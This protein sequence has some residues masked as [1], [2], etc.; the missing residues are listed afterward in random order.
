MN[1][2]MKMFVFVLILGAITSLLL[3]GMDLLTA[4]RI[5]ANENANLY[6]A[7]LDSNEVSYNFGTI[8]NTFESEITVVEED[9]YTLYYHEASGNVSF[10]FIGGGVWGPIEGVLTLESDFETIVAMKI[11]QQEETPGL[12]GII[13][14]PEYLA[15]YEGVKMVPEIDITHSN[16]GD[17]NQVDAITGGTRT[18]NSVEI[19]LNNT[20][21][22][23]SEVWDSVSER[24]IG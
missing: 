14:N 5:E 20:Y 9:E 1:Q 23:Y 7:I 24:V 6:A 22:E 13:A 10:V 19:I 11:L 21:A 12:G 2:Y 8:S 4:E 18:S 3:V 15:T 17:D 16:Q